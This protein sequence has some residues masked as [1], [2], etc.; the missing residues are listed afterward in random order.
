MSPPS[1]PAP[2]VRPAAFRF[3]CIACGD[4]SDSAAQNFRCA[5]CGDLLEITYPQGFGLDPQKLKSTWRQ[6]RLSEAPIDQS[7][8]WR[9]RE[10]LPALASEDQAITLREGNTPLVP[11]S[12]LRA[13]CRCAA[14]V[15]QASGNESHRLVQRRR[16]D[17]R[18]N[19]RAPRRVSL[20]GLRFHGQHVGVHGGLRRSR[21]PAQPGAGSRRQNFLEQTFAGARLWRCDLPTAYGFRRLPA[22]PAGTR[23]CARRSTS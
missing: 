11:T 1:S 9:F 21:R 22:D 4:V 7:G 19:L 2:G 13:Q 15:R 23:V 10:L 8:V 16:H 5:Q 20:G 3:R 12:A 6:R 18:R 17:G 14:A